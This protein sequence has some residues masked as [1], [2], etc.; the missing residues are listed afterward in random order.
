MAIRKSSSS[1]IPF[2]NNAGRPANPSSGQPYFNGQEKRL[3][4]YT[5]A[6]WQNIVSETPGVVSVSG[7]YLESVGSATLE[8]TGTNFTTG[9]IASVIGTNGVEI[10]ASSTTVN[11]IV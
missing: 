4:L 5:S 10:N 3:E 7:S 8:I 6:G 1:G 9:A 11:S 2:G